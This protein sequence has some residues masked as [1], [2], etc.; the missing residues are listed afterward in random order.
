MYTRKIIGEI[1]G[2]FMKINAVIA[3]YNP[4]HNGHRYLLENAGRLIGADYTIAVVSGNFVQRGAPA[5][6]DKHARTEMA[7]Q[8]GVDLVLELPAVYATASA[9]Y[10]A[11]GAV[12]LLERLGVVT[13][14]SFGSE[15]GD[16]DS[17]RRVALLLAEE[18][19]S[20]SERLQA[21]L[22]QG[23]SYPTA[24]TEVL[25]KYLPEPAAHREQLSSPNNILG[26]EYIKALLRQ[27]SDIEPVTVRRVGT[28]YHDVDM[29]RCIGDAEAAF[30][31]AQ[32]LRLAIFDGKPISELARCLPESVTALLSSHLSD[33]AL[34]SE[35]DLSDILYYKLLR[36]RESGYEQYLDV[37]RELSDRIRKRLQE[38]AGFHAFCDLLK[39]KE[40]THTR[41]SRSLLHVLLDITKEDADLWRSQGLIPYARVLGFRRD[42]AELLSAI[43]EK[44]DI[45]LITK[46]ADAEKIL[47]EETF[48][49][50]QKELR[51]SQLYLGLAAGKKGGVPSNE[52]TV[53][54]VIL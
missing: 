41:I 38:Y 22:R 44:S 37:S 16:L 18:P 6:L 48:R 14:L 31:S 12:A 36:E 8:N 3:E 13:H 39:T 47:P 53:P 20:F 17:L 28:G 10:F 33:N 30:C 23:L 9:E 26:I 1:L 51:I 50:F 27:G 15:C 34:L 52:Y 40:M 5:L 43:K 45:P 49:L 46:L 42:A 54:L 35:N 19:E 24:R 2:Y 21:L 32:A 7:L 25:M 29:S 4:F 11:A